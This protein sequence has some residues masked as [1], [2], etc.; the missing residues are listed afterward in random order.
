MKVQKIAI[1]VLVSPED[2][3]DSLRT[4]IGLQNAANGIREQLLPNSIV[5][6]LAPVKVDLAEELARY[7]DEEMEKPR[8]DRCRD[9]HDPDEDCDPETLYELSEAHRPSDDRI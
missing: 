1:E 5:R 3:I 6:V 8:C 9:R 4:W 2:D 7:E